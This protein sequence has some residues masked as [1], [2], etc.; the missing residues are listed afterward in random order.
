[1]FFRVYINRAVDTRG[2]YP[3][4]SGFSETVPPASDRILGLYP[5]ILR[6]SGC[7]YARI[8]LELLD[9]TG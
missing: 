6:R 2:N 4:F 7:E 5:I 3:L 8:A 1:M 9:A